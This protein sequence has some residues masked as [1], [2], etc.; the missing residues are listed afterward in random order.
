MCRR[1]VCRVRR[2][3]ADAHNLK[4]SVSGRGLEEVPCGAASVKGVSASPCTVGV[5]RQS[6]FLRVVQHITCFHVLAQGSQL[7][8][9]TVRQHLWRRHRQERTEHMLHM[10][11]LFHARTCSSHAR[12]PCTCFA[13]P[14]ALCMLVCGCV[15]SASS[16]CVLCSLLFVPG[17]YNQLRCGRRPASHAVSMSIAQR[18]CCIRR[19]V[20][21]G[22]FVW[23]RG[24]SWAG[25]CTALDSVC[26][27]IPLHRLGAACCAVLCWRRGGRFG[28]GYVLCYAMPC[29]STCFGGGPQPLCEREVQ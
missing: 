14:Y 25:M 18:V 1:A 26:C 9:A 29:C 27:C 10:L 17:P 13:H 2:C 22:E 3:I 8:M 7:V 28:G 6:T 12:A 20:S 11:H 19:H 15:A 24:R 16:K 5:G 23:Q 21:L 4:S